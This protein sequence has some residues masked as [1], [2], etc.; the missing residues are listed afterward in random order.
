ML[1]TG[2]RGRLSRLLAVALAQRGHHVVVSSRVADTRFIDCREAASA[3]CLASFDAVLHLA[4]STVPALAERSPG[5]EWQT[6]LPWLAGMLRTLAGLPQ[7][8]RPQ[9][10]F[11]SSGGTVYGEAPAGRGSREDDPCRPI[12]WY[13]RAKLAAERL[14][15]DFTLACGLDSTVLRVA[16][17]YGYLL[18]PDKPQ[19][20]I[21]HLLHSAQT[22]RPAVVWGDGSARKDYLAAGDLSEAVGRVIE[23]R[24]T[25]LYNLGSGESHTVDEVIA[26]VRA[27]TGRAFAVEYREGFAWDVHCSRL[28]VR[29][30][31]QRLAWCPRIAPREGIERLW[32]A[33]VTVS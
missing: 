11:F 28:D 21:A 15:D 26:L 32:G 18:D 2:G 8:G 7:E 22:G 27:V 1:I 12:G 19:G 24:A 3:A 5:S 16:N 29:R 31:E 10:V 4:W 17:P 9:L 33:Q 23:L 20:L 6:D 25:G 13:G 14:I 30:I